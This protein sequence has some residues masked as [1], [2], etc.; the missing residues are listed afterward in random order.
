MS[1][2]APL[3]SLLIAAPLLAALPCLLAKREATVRALAAAGALLALLLSLLVVLQFDG[4][5]GGFQ[6]VETYPWIPGLGIH[7]QVGVDGLSLLFL[8][9]TALLFL[10][11][12]VTTGR[13]LKPAPGQHFALLLWLETA[14]LGVFCALDTMLIFFFWEM[15]LLPVY[16]LTAQW[17][18]GGAQAGAGAA[19]A[20]ANAGR[21]AATRYV[22]I[23]VAGGVPLLFALLLLGA[24]AGMHFDLPTLLAASPS[25]GLQLL[26]F[27]LFLLGFGIK[28]PLV[29]LHSWLP[30]LALASPATTTALLVGLK[31][32]AYGL[33]RLAVPLAPLAARELHWLLGG[34]GTV[35][36]LYG[37]VAAL[38]QG[39][40]R[41]V[42]ACA[43]I[44]HVGLAVLGLASFSVAGLQGVVL[45]L[46]TFSLASGGGFLLLDGLQRRVGSCDLAAL[47]G[48]R[49]RM[50][51]LAGFF[52]LFG[53]AAMGLPGTSGFPAEFLIIVTT[54][55]EHSGA[56]L[57]AL[58]GMVVGAGAFLA[59]YRSAFF[60]PLRHAA[61]AEAD[62]LT[63][64]EFLLM[65]VFA[66]L[67]VAIGLFPQWLLDLIRPAAE[68]WVRRLS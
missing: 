35:G 10:A 26:V 33:L 13:G 9:A 15:S 3:L 19:S 22:L 58:F 24:D 29:P 39:N 18:A 44:S 66:V 2:N 32:G 57:A 63:R 47:S 68:L 51:R 40:L 50:P 65:A 34:L 42:Q 62:D 8:P 31:L 36:I 41:S 23:M 30:S 17:P 60:G 54:L 12:V 20:S 28:V 11:A 67:I 55:Q 49:R 5:D 7:F 16:F 6:Q 27:L 48:V 1:L 46:L 21:S 56:A 64:R 43:S 38:A 4:G 14:T 61:V 53:L 59:P 25:R 37:A 52:L 45:L